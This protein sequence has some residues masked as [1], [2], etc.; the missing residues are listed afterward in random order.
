MLTDDIG[1]EVRVTRKRLGLRQEEVAS[2]C[3]VGT[4]FLS[5]LENGKSTLELGRVI[6]VLDALGLEL[7]LQPRNPIA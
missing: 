3:G 2:L 6:R 5:E 4:R 1:R 7:I